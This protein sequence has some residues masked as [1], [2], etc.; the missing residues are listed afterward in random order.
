MTNRWTCRLCMLFL[1][2]SPVCQAQGQEPT[3]R[4]IPPAVGPFI[5]LKLDALAGQILPWFRQ[6]RHD[7]RLLLV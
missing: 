4:E 5:N 3:A 6:D 7:A 2:F 1:S